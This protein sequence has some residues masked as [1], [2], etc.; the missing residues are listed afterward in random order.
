MRFIAD[1]V[2]KNSRNYT[3]SNFYLFNFCTY[4]DPF[5]CNINCKQDNTLQFLYIVNKQINNKEVTL[6]KRQ[7][8]IKLIIIKLLPR[9]KYAFYPVDIGFK[10]A[11]ILRRLFY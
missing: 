4:T 3:E 11:Y 1:S 8:I 6:C 10:D 7:I 9:G 2:P 5:D